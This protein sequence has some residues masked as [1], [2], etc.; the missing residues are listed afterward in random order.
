MSVGALRLMLSPGP[1][2]RTVAV[3]A[4]TLPAAHDSWG[5]ALAAQRA[6]NA[7]T[8]RALS[9]A[10]LLVAILTGDLPASGESW[11]PKG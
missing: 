9:R 7:A 10:R 6:A 1:A 8:A 5:D 3:E 11:P 4:T 2:G